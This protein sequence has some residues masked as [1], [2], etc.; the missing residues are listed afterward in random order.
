MVSGHFRSNAVASLSRGHGG[1]APTFFST[2]IDF[3]RGSLSSSL[4]ALNPYSSTNV[5]TSLRRGFGMGFRDTEVPFG[6]NR[7]AA[8]CLS[9]FTTSAR[10]SSTHLRSSGGCTVASTSLAALA[11]APPPP[12]PLTPPPP[13]PPPPPSASLNLKFRSSTATLLCADP[14]ACRFKPCARVLVVAVVFAVGLARD[15][16]GTA[17]MGAAVDTGSSG[18]AAAKDKVGVGPPPPPP[19]E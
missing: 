8:T 17:G 16:H 15:V 13:P 7:S 3:P 14:A 2:R 4:M 11:N 9:I 6:S 5:N 19:C 12:P 10:L 18:N 1:E